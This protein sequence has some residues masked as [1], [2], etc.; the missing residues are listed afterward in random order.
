[1]QLFIGGYG[2]RENT[3]LHWLSYH[4]E[5]NKLERIKSFS[6]IESPSYLT[7]NK[8]T[9]CLYAISEI[10]QGKIVSYKLDPKK[11][12][13]TEINQKPAEGAPCFIEAN[14]TDQ[15]LLT[16]NYGNGSIIAHH[17]HKDGAIG[18]VLFY[19]KFA[20]HGKEVSRIHTF[21]RVKQTDFYVAVDIGLS[22]LYVY[23]FNKDAR[24]FQKEH[25][26]Q[27]P[28]KSGPRDIAFHPN[29]NI[30][31]VVNEYE[32]TILAYEH[33]HAMNSMEEIQSIPSIPAD[34]KGKN[35]GAAIVI[36]H[37]GKT[38][39]V[40]NR[41]H[42]SITVCGIEADGT[43]TQNDWIMLKGEWPRHFITDNSSGYLFVANEHSDSIEIVDL[44]SKQQE[45]LAGEAK[46]IHRPACIKM[47]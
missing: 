17:L 34:F 30:F 31:Y 13:L 32:D 43:L 7:L 3:N 44:T 45:Q 10:E 1:M 39:Y 9:N 37:D 29:K 26:H 25:E 23:D 4:P 20:D 15:L 36:D 11:M 8:Q 2:T 21:K 46:R 14:E 6:G 33:N 24:M 18:D 41:G 12:Q 16:A 38:V 5:T 19:E 35:Y 42:H 27:L 28:E 47:L 22:K 40:S